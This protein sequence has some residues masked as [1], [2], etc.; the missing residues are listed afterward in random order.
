MLIM[1]I[2]GDPYWMWMQFYVFDDAIIDNLGGLCD[3]R[4][5]GQL[6]QTVSLMQYLLHYGETFAGQTREYL[7]RQARVY[8]GDGSL[9]LSFWSSVGGVCVFLCVCVF[10]CEKQKA[11][12]KQRNNETSYG[13][14]C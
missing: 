11:E 14:D 5:N 7:M 1:G 3:P 12:N 13:A 9:L 4:Y 2:Y 8:E 6:I 10:Q